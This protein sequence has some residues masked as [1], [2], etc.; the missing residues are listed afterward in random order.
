VGLQTDIKL[1]NIPPDSNVPPK[2]TPPEKVPTIAQPKITL[3][4]RITATP[5]KE[6]DKV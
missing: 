1:G 6:G 3:T 5:R 4:S 2:E